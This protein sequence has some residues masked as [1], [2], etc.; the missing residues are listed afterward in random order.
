MD[1]AWASR[2]GE[3]A[4]NED[5]AASGDGW[6]FVLDGATAPQGAEE[7]CGHGVHWTVRRLAAE[8]AALLDGVPGEGARR[9][10]LASALEEATVRTR[11]AHGPGCDPDHPDAP[12]T[13][14]AAVR[15]APGGL[16]YLVLADSAVL[17]PVPG[18]P[19][20]VLTDDRLDRLPGGRPYSPA[21]VRAMRNAPGGFWVAGSRP[22]AAREALTG[23]RPF[24][25]APD[26]SPDRRFALLTDGCTRL[27]ERFGHGWDRVWKCLED[28]GPGALVSWV[29]NEEVRAAP[30]RGKRHDDATALLGRLPDPGRA[31]QARSASPFSPEATSWAK[32]TARSPF[33]STGSSSP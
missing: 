5:V 22:E 9:L 21:L 12:A 31:P 2:P 15:A 16:E 28:V 3:G 19:P 11:A 27:A 25:A 17:L 13:T 23:V 29:R 6:A 7:A 26:G 30:P 20:E 18:G 24:P 4:F 14:V 10:P 1:I 33:S 32:S 8:L